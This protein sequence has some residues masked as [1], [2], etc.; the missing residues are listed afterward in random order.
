VTLA[1]YNPQ[2]QLVR[3]LAEGI[4][5]AGYHVAAWDGTNA[6]GH[7]VSGGVYYCKLEAGEFVQMR[8]MVYVK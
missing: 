7:E 5:P 3:T 6:A 2:G 1:I 4:R 8:K